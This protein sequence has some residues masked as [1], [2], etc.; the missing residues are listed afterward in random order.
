MK[1]LVESVKKYWLT[2]VGV[3]VSILALFKFRDKL[4]TILSK[5]KLMETKEKRRSYGNRG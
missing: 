5:E 1:K 2:V 4:D 3:L